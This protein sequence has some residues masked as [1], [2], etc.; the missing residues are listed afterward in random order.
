MVP[1]VTSHPAAVHQ[2]Q[3]SVRQKIRAKAAGY[4]D[5]FFIDEVFAGVLDHLGQRHAALPVLDDFSV[6]FLLI[7][8]RKR[9]FLP[10]SPSR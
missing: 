5:T 9:G 8:L 1:Y 7:E 6:A 10:H 3:S 2:V 4:G